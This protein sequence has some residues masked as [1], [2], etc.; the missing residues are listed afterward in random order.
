MTDNLR[1]RIIAVLNVHGVELDDSRCDCGRDCF[2][3]THESL[4]DYVQHVADAVIAE[5]DL[6]NRITSAIC[7]Y[8]GSE[9]MALTHHSPNSGGTE[10]D[11]LTRLISE[12]PKIARYAMKYRR[13]DGTA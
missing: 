3:R 7:S 1:D 12:A 13:P 11:A 2:D 4:S 10:F 6:E 9:Q 8:A 5:L